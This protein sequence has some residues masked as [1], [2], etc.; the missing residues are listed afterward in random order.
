MKTFKEMSDEEVAD[1]IA[2]KMGWTLREH[3]VW[4]AENGESFYVCESPHH[5]VC[6]TWNPMRSLDQCWIFEEWLIE[7]EH[8]E[9]FDILE[10][11]MPNDDGNRSWSGH[12]TAAQRCDAFYLTMGGI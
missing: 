6:L 10:I 9:Y 1:F 2:E 4:V 7:N 12:A 11:S 3:R 5:C 8:T